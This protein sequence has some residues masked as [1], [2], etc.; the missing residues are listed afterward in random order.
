[1]GFTGAATPP[2]V[3]FYFACAKFT[4]MPKIMQMLFAWYAR[5]FASSGASSVIEETP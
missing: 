5:T 2:T 3:A 4:L 1:V